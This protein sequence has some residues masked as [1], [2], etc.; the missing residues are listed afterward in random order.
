MTEPTAMG[1]TA[2][3]VMLEEIEARPHGFAHGALLGACFHSRRVIEQLRIQVLRLEGMVQEKSARLA[4][5]REVFPMID[6]KPYYRD[7]GS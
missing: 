4:R 7:P 3:L 1:E 2:L 5:V 6:G